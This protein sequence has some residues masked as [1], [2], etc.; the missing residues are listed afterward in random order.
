MTIST[1]EFH[2]HITAL[3]IAAVAFAALHGSLLI[4]FESLASDGYH[5]VNASTRVAKSTT[6]PRTTTLD[7][8]VITTRRV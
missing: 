6:A 3:A 8:V 4:G 7:R 1:R 2:F 5:G